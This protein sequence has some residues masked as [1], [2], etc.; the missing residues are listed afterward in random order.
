MEV[1][2]WPSPFKAPPDAM[3]A[4]DQ[5]HRSVG[6]IVS[7]IAANMMVSGERICA[8]ESGKLVDLAFSHGA[9]PWKFEPGYDGLKDDEKKKARAAVANAI[10]KLSKQYWSGAGRV[11]PGATQRRKRAEDKI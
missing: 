4:L 6:I 10:A 9:F 8:V 2:G 7:A 11:F 5:T 1:A 3:D